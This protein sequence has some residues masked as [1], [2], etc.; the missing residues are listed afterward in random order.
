[1]LLSTLISGSSK[2]KIKTVKNLADSDLTI[3]FD[4]VLYMRIYLNVTL[5]RSNFN[6][7][8]GYLAFSLF[9]GDENARTSLFNAEKT[10]NT[11]ISSS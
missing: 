11:A 4:N 9:S 3:G 1:M 10:V 2:N 5:I 6:G 8:F 7:Y